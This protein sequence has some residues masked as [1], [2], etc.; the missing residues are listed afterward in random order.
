MTTGTTADPLASAAILDI[1]R[2][3]DRRLAIL[4]ATESS[5]LEDA[6]AERVLR[7]EA[8]VAMFRAID[9]HRNAH[10]LAQAGGVSTRAGQSFV[11]EILGTGLASVVPNTKGREVIIARDEDAIVRWYVDQVQGDR[12]NGS[13]DQSDQ[14]GGHGRT[15]AAPR[16]HRAPDCGDDHEGH[17]PEGLSPDSRR[18]RH[19]P[20]GGRVGA[21]HRG[22]PRRSRDLEERKAQ[23]S[24]KSTGKA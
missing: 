3:I 12:A 7:T 10:E 20:E 19:L 22:Q 6:L 11:K 5:R 17:E 4:T 9:G 18:G 14:P 8:R 16:S 23:D 1:L 24:K 2:S 21:W 13:G 15:E